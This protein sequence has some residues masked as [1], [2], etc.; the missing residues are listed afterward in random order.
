M[1][2]EPFDLRLAPIALAAWGSAALGLGWSTGQTV[3]GAMVLLTLGGLVVV[4][5]HRHRESTIARRRQVSPRAGAGAH[6]LL[7]A[8]FIVAAAAL[9]VSGLHTGA[10]NAGPIPELAAQRAQVSVR[11]V[12]VSDPV[13]KEGTFT[14]YVLVRVRVSEVTGRGRTTRIRSPVLVI[15]D[16]SW[17]RLEFGDHIEASG[18]LQPGQGVDIAAVLV[19]DSDPRVVTWASRLDRAVGSVRA[20]LREAVSP[21]PPAQRALVPALV[22][23]DDSAMPP[24]VVADFKTTGLTHL[25]AVSGSNLTLVL[26]FVL[27]TA[28]SCRVRARGLVVLGLVA[29]VFFVLL[30]RPQPSVLRAAAMG[31]V[32]LVGLSSGGRR[33]GIRS[34][35]VAVTVLVLLDPILARSL[36]FLLSTAATAGILLLAPRWR[37][38]LTKWMPRALAEAIAVPLAAQV[39]CTPAIAA[40]SGQVSMVSVISNLL[41]A[42]AVGPTTV[43]GLLAGLIA[44]VSDRL[45][46][47]AGHLAGTPAWWIVWVASHTADFAGSSVSWPVGPIALTVLTGLCL[48][49]VF[50]MPRTLSSPTGALACVVA[51][52]LVVVQPLGR[53][54][55]PPHGWVMV[56]CDVGQGD[57]MV[58]NAGHG[59]AVVVDTGPDPSLMDRCLD[60]L[61]VDTVALILLTHFHADHVN[62]LPGALDGR[63]VTEIETTNLRDPPDRATAVD[64]WADDADVPVTVATLGERRTIG[65][66]S[67]TVIGPVQRSA[68]AGGGSGEG[69]AP[70][71][72]SVVLMLDTQGH[73]F[74]LSGDAEPEEEDDMMANGA[75]LGADVF[76]VAHHGSANQDPAYVFATHAALALISVG[77]D[78]DYGHPAPQTLGLLQQLGA[79]TYRTDHD[80]DIAVVSRAGQLAVLTSD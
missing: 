61:D 52:I 47:L 68:T 60:R 2:R 24:D 5:E 63:S 1:T 75:D 14:P 21:L 31:V 12:V 49:A 18:R 80:G 4:V 13:M 19:G 76:K 20:G 67:W 26:A 62:G 77:A 56:M 32:A 50:A 71:N 23:G 39:A 10:V 35:S 45:A 22:D 36:G 78:N 16:P 44:L 17:L 7:A 33:H 65:A 66:L 64:H 53:L 11:S 54:G 74:L 51:L 79:H 38:C 8:V 15:G 9:A 57:G 58:L 3:I 59:V 72:A 48:V 30:A 6:H 73:R 40:I 29:V 28:R 69:S 37:D 25:L 41:A 55:W 42:P 43:I 46:H 70:N 27:V 34:L